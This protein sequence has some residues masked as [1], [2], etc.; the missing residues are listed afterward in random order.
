MP[1]SHWIG[2][3]RPRGELPTRGASG[4]SDAELPAILLRTGTRGK[5]AIDLAGGLLAEFAGLPALLRSSAAAVSLAHNSPSQVAV[6]G[7]TDPASV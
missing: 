3:E 4:L 2:G 5:T 6:R 1:I 7:G